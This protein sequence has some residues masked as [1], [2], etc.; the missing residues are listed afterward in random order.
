MNCYWC[1]Y[2][3]IY[4][5]NLEQGLNWMGYVVFGQ[6]VDVDLDVEMLVFGMCIRG[7]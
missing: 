2:N 7:C 4:V 6:K 1:F 5:F 3:L